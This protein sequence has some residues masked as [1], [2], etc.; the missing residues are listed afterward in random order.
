[1]ARKSKSQASVGQL[2]QLGVMRVAFRLGFALAPGSTAERAARLFLSPQQGPP[3]NLVTPQGE[4]TRLVIDGPDMA[5]TGGPIV[6]WSWGT[7]P[8]VLV[9]HG[10]EGEHRR[11]TP[12]IDRLTGAGYRV[13]AMDLPGHG[14]SAGK[15]VPIPLL[16]RA[17]GAVGAKLGPVEAVVGHSLGGTAAMLALTELG[18]Q[19]RKAVIIASPNH[20]AHFARQVIQMLGLGESHFALTA[21]AIERLAGRPMDSLF[22]PPLLRKL[23][24]PALFLHDPADEVVPISHTHDNSGAWPGAKLKVLEGPG[25]RRI[26]SDEEALKAILEFVRAED[27][28]AETGTA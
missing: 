11:M 15:L 26:L 9:V 4:A 21:Q 17:V 13:V 10:W 20:P 19:A 14:A 23:D 28:R 3:K 5:T 1:M 27:R 6:A 7:G 2:L 18:L 22:L 12:I 24:L 16:A 25:H 8:T